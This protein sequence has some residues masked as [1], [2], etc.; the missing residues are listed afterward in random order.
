MKLFWMVWERSAFLI[1]PPAEILPDA[2][3][4]TRF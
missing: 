4:K 1:R 2:L 3:I